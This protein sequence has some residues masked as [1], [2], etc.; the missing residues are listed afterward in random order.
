MRTLIKTSLKLLFRSKIFWFFLVA[1]PVLSTFILKTKFDSSAAYTER[2]DEEILEL[3]DADDKVAYF[4]GQGEYMLKVYDNAKSE[5]S[6]YL[7]NKLAKSGLVR[8]CRVKLGDP[9]KDSGR[10]TDAWIK[11]R[12]DKDGYEDRMGAALYLTEEFDAAVKEGRF[13]DALTVYILS[14]DPRNDLLESEIR[15]QLA[16]IAGTADPAALDAR[17]PEK[18]VVSIAGVSERALTDRQVNCKTHIGYAFAFM[19]LGFVF[20]G[21]FVAHTAINE[22]KNGVYTRVNLT[23]AGTHTYFLSKLLTTLIVVSLST[24][25]MGLCSL[26]LDMDD[27]GMGRLQFLMMILLMGMIFGSL[28][29]TVGIL[30][31]DVMSANVASFT[32]WCMSALFSGLYFPLKDASAGIKMLSSL[33]P[34]KW[35]LEVTEMI[36]VRDN[37]AYVML[38]CIT[39]GYLLLT[40]SFGSLGLKLRRT[41]EWGDS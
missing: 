19:T 4:G 8:V 35:F 41:D 22:Q 34:Q 2:E 9:E 5:Y 26:M 1:A 16:K 24:G 25:V 30:I 14:D 31:G 15:S 17:L 37:S 40:L 33:M 36:F 39:A 10:I 29:M 12:I 6:E 11:N 32:V 23:K 13:T 3:D 20:C 27:L 28:S 18:H 7:L 38:L 21:I